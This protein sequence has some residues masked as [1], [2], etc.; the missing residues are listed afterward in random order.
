MT[1]PRMQIGAV[2]ITAPPA[3]H[4]PELARFYERLLGWRIVDE[5]PKGG[6]VQ[7]HPPEGETGRTLL[8]INIESDQDHERPVW[9]SMPGGQNATMHLDIGVDDLDEAV[10]WALQAGASL[11]E[12]Q[13]QE[14]V[15]V[16]LDPAGNPFC[17]CC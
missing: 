10:A 14:H 17:L 8:G 3:P 7:L 15:R 5:G 12:H 16:M 9:P 13:P 6:W 11:A 1:R 4:A 2:T